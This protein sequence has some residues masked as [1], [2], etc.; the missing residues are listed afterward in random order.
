MRRT[1]DWWLALS[2]PLL[3]GPVW[4][5]TYTRARRATKQHVPGGHSNGQRQRAIAAH[6]PSLLRGGAEWRSR[7]V[8][9][10]GCAARVVG[11]GHLYEQFERLHLKQLHLRAERGLAVPPQ[12]RRGAL[13]HGIVRVTVPR[14]CSASRHS[15][16]RRSW[17][18]PMRRCM[19]RVARWIPRCT[20]AMRAT[21]RVRSVTLVESAIDL[22]VQPYCTAAEP[23][24]AGGMDQR[25]YLRDTT[26]ANPTCDAGAYEAPPSAL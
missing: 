2:G 15:P 19:P 3:A 24:G 5:L 16:P 21:C 12:P 7:S 18:S 26:G 14:V 9:D 4:N 11:R 25:G 6:N 17:R 1:R 23:Q 8:G 13:C 20:S 22:G 10:R